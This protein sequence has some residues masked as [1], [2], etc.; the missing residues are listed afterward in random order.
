[1]EQSWFWGSGIHVIHGWMNTGG[2]EVP[3]GLLLAMGQCCFRG[4]EFGLFFLLVVFFF[5]KNLSLS[6]KLRMYSPPLGF[7]CLVA[8]AGGLPNSV[9]L[10]ALSI[11]RICARRSWSLVALCVSL[12]LVNKETAQELWVCLNGVVWSHRVKLRIKILVSSDT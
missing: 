8:A 4:E 5:W 10:V 9:I 11:P 7:C 3:A 1:M 12:M 6:R 2:L